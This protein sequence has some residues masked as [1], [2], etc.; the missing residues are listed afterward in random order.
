[1]KL[2]FTFSQI[3]AVMLLLVTIAAT[4]QK[5]GD[6]I[7]TSPKP[8]AR[9]I[10]PEQ[11]LLFKAGA[12]FDESSAKPSMITLEGTK[13]GEISGMMKFSADGKTMLFD[14]SVSFKYDEKITVS[15]EAGIQTIDGKTLSKTSFSFRTAPAD[16]EHLI[17]EYYKNQHEKQLL[18]REE[19]F[20]SKTSS[21]TK[22]TGN[23][24]E[25]GFPDNYP[26]LTVA[27]FNNPSQGKIFYTPSGFGD[28]DYDAYLVASDN[29]GTPVFYMETIH[30]GRDF[31]KINDSTV[32]YCE[33]IY[34]SPS[35][36]KYLLMD[37]SYH[38][39]DTLL[40]EGYY[41]DF[42]DLV[43]FEDGGHILFAYDPQPV[44]MDTVVEGGDPNA[45]VT[46]LVIQEFDEEGN[47]VFQWESWNNYE[48]TDA[49]EHIDLT[50]GSID[51]VHANAMEIDH[52]GN[53]LLSNRHMDEI[54]KIDRITGEIMW[55][56]GLNAKQNQFELINDTMGFYHQHDIKILENGNY[57]LYDNGNWHSPPF[58]QSL[59]YSLDTDNMTAEK[60]W[61]YSNDPL[62]FGF[63]TGSSRRLANGNTI[64]C[65][66]FTSPVVFTEV[67][68]D[69]EKTWEG[70]V[71]NSVVNYRALRADW[72]TDL[73]EISA[74]TL[75]YGTFTGYTEIPRIIQIQNNADYEIEISSAHNHLESYSVAT[76]LP[77]TIPAND[78][79]NLTVNFFPQ[80]EE[81][82]L[83]DVLT[84]NYD[85]HWNDTLRKRIAK[86]VY[87]KGF[88]EDNNA[89]GVSISPEDGAT[90]VPNAST[91]K[92]TFSEPVD[93]E[94][95]ETLTVYDLPDILEFK[96]GGEDGE[97]V[98]YTAAIDMW[99]EVITIMPDT[100][101]PESEYYV[102]LKG[103]MVADGQGNV[104]SESYTSTFT[105]EEESAI[106]ENELAGFR[107]YP[108]PTSGMLYLESEKNE[109]PVKANVYNR[110]G[111]LVTTAGKAPVQQ[112]SLHHFSEGVYF[113]ELY[114]EDMERTASF[115]VIKK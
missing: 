4:A 54:T 107:M 49:S 3:L 73:F 63:A 41:V 92:I 26:P 37:K 94:N 31:R 17:K 103:N 112:L 82:Q 34:G 79:K 51:Y 6:F 30:S 65:W 46:G 59:E 71:P 16:N 11:T 83:N 15:V 47:L 20:D 87:L 113:V 19:H 48:I 28:S 80:D 77:M 108:N 99:K 43:Y 44:A 21:S 101:I 104:V 74:D 67:T 55:R 32:A 115:K 69:K 12:T 114:F 35:V 5:K 29:Y 72:E 7:Y 89:P 100:L 52:D 68:Y 109:Y 58:S 2:T 33:S 75:D 91:I 10:Q 86:Q 8:G 64:I 111:R 110:S 98:E 38:I 105:I 78:S 88:V 40:M 57:T 45:T 50:A 76:S 27:E 66:G 23:A 24:K 84:L 13:S 14:P 81:G 39:T 90:E 22:S 18:Q 95:G 61:S 96:K 56:F 102:K 1:M 60:I 106:G 36:N 62:V 93:K 9:F 42:H 25:M 85:T 70:L 97:A 53:L